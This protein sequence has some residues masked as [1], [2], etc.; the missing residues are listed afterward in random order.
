MRV[1]FYLLSQDSAEKAVA[2]ISKATLKAGQRLLVVG[3][4]E[5]LDRAL[6]E[7][8]ATEFLAHG[9]ADAPHAERQPILLSSTCE[10]ANGAKFI[11]LADGQWRDE[12]LTFERVFLIFDDGSRGGARECWRMLGSKDGIERHFWKQEDGRWIEQA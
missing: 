6:W 1:D 3:G 11:A 9:A 8:A 10:A 4:S 7:E 5:G 2:L 12:A